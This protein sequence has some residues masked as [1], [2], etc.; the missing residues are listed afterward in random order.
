MVGQVFTLQKIKLIKQFNKLASALISYCNSKI[1]SLKA[2]NKSEFQN[3]FRFY[4][5]VCSSIEDSTLS[6]VFSNYVM[7]YVV[8]E[9]NDN[10]MKKSEAANFILSLFILDKSNSRVKDNLT[11][12]FEMLARDESTD[13]DKAVKKILEKVKAIDTNFY[14]RLNDENEQA[15]IDKELNDIVNKLTSKSMSESSALQKVYSLY[16]TNNNH[17][18]ICEI[19][20][21]LCVA[22]IMKYVIKEEYGGHAVTTV[23]NSLEDNMSST[24]KKHRKH[25]K[26]AHDSIWNSL[27]SDAKLTIQGLNPHATL[28][29]SGL[30]LKQGLKWY[31]RL[32]GFTPPSS[33]SD[34]FG[35]F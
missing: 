24:F 22:C 10:S 14:H 13:S 29:S 12:L 5:S 33:I 16:K 17:D 30:A 23:L 19:L 7:Q 8:S 18:A 31:Q 3:N 21:Q 6:F 1:S 9:V 32:G 11:T 27:P 4:S 25:F 15:I 34:L 35:L 20:A 26:E 2:N 28:N